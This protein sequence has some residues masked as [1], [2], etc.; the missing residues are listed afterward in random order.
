MAKISVKSGNVEEALRKF[1]RQCA[2]E[3]IMREAR[4]REAYVAPSLKKKLKAEEA[5]KRNSKKRKKW[6]D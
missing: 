3:G 4:K 1:K 5:R 2:Q 6:G